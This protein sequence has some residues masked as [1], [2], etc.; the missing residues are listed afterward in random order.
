M[1]P[2]PGHV[3]NGNLADVV[4]DHIVEGV[5]IISVED[6]TGYR[7]DEMDVDELEKFLDEIGV[8]YIEQID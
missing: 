4:V 3:Y 2:K 6:D 5:A 1:K 8:Y 7:Y